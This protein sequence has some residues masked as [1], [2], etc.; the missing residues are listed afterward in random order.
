MDLARW[1][2]LKAP[3][4]LLA[5]LL[6]LGGCGAVAGAGAGV[7]VAAVQE[8]GIKRKA[9]DLEIEALI[10]DKFLR[11]DLKMTATV[12]VEVY[13]G[14]VLVT[15]ALTNKK[16]ADRAVRF[17]WQVKGVKQVINEIQLVP[18]GIADYAQ[19]TW[20]TVQLK[21]VLALD[22]QVMAINYVIETVNG[23]VYLIGVAQ[24]RVELNRVIAH[25][26]KTKFVRRVISHV[27]LKSSPKSGKRPS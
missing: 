27:R 25:A 26:N 22:N 6:I 24:D 16:T 3:V 20:V 13:E 8:R 17:A 7:G 12:G 5:C 19:D 15:G 11:S 1:K 21:S 23:T 14:R 9:Q 2:K 10:L 4:S 18:T